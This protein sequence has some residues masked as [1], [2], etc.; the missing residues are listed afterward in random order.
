MAAGPG[1][2][3]AGND[4]IPVADYADAAVAA[5]RRARK[6]RRGLRTDRPVSELPPNVKL[7]PVESHWWAGLP[8]LPV[9]ES[10]AV[11]SGEAGAGWAGLTEDRSG[12]YSDFFVRL[13][14]IF[15]DGQGGLAPGVV[16]EVSRP[17]GGVRFRSGKVQHYTLSKMGY[18]RAGGRY[19]LFLKN[20]GQGFYSILTGYE[21]RGDRVLPLDGDG[22]DPRADLQFGRY[23]G[24]S[25]QSFLNDLWQA[26]YS[27]PGPGGSN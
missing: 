9:G 10:D 14:T 15:K 7:L 3:A 27:T 12:I 6:T 16:I 17:G 18:P 11:V 20:D 13:D 4:T 25:Q 5:G 19:V 2:D 1:Q 22:R 26:V 8:A 21:L 23:R 24:A